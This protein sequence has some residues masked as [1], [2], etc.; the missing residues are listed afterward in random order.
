MR[1]Y[2]ILYLKHEEGY[3]IRICKSCCAEVCDYAYAN[4]F[5][6]RACGRW[7]RGW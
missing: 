2:A 1:L 5:I 6:C 4:W 7:M 3:N